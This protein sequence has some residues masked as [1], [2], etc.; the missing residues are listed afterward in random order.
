VGHEP[1]RPDGRSTGDG[2]TVLTR[3]S[4]FDEYAVLH[5]PDPSNP[6]FNVPVLPWTA[7]P[8][9]TVNL[10]AQDFAPGI[11]E[12]DSG[13]TAQG[14]TDAPLDQRRGFEVHS[15]DVIKRVESLSL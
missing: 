1:R 12:G 6:S 4:F 11:I 7:I 8:F 5:A 3:A 2:E 14:S 9:G 15:D 13:S 10:A